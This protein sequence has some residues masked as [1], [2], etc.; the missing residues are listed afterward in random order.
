MVT[1]LDGRVVAVQQDS[2]QVLWTFDTGTPL[3]TVK[4]G[5]SVA[6]GLRIFPGVDGGL[7]AYGTAL[8]SA[9]GSAGA[10]LEVRAVL[11]SP[12]VAGTRLGRLLVKSS[13]TH[14]VQLNQLSTS[15]PQH[16]STALCLSQAQHGTPT[17]TIALLSRP[18]P[19]PTLR[20]GTSRHLTHT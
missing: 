9:D 2:G 11:P 3:V 4:Q 14:L 20:T 7:Y 18:C 19:I 1:L 5:Q 15:T 10:K 6:P 16:S 8:A 12:A 17:A 13:P